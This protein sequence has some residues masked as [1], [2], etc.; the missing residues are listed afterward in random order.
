MIFSCNVA[1]VSEK[2][3]YLAC[4]SCQHE[5][6][7]AK[8]THTYCFHCKKIQRVSQRFLFRAEIADGTGSLEISLSNPEADVFLGVGAE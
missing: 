8:G 2:R 1:N 7:P 3:E 6:K 5:T 4:L